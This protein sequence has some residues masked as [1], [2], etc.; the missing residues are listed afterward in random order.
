MVR[1]YVE[2]DEKARSFE[3]GVRKNGTEA[4]AAIKGGA[5]Q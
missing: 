3:I 1:A 5:S 4:G 2:S